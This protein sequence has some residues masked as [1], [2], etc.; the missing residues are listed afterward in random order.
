[1][2][3]SFLVTFNSFGHVETDVWFDGP[4]RGRW[5]TVGCLSGELLCAFFSP[6]AKT[7]VKRDFERTFMKSAET[8]KQFQC[9]FFWGGGGEFIHLLP[10]SRYKLK[11]RCFFLDVFS[12]NQS[13][14]SVLRCHETA[15]AA[16]VPWKAPP[17]SRCFGVHR[18]RHLHSFRLINCKVLGA[19][20]AGW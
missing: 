4:F 16:F 17:S 6:K 10:K 18:W 8:S 5:R 15:F 11:D 14:E 20:Q 9:F 3:P 2:L 12:Q 7:S 19:W 13:R 1:M